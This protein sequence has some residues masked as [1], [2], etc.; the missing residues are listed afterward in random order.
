MLQTI[1]FAS[2]AA[3]MLSVFMVGCASSTTANT[4]H[5]AD[6]NLEVVHAAFER[7]RMGTGGPFE[8]L[9][10]ETTW[11]IVGSSPF[12]KTY[13]SKKHFMDEVIGPFNARLTRPLVPTVRRLYADGD[14]VVALFDGEALAKDGIVYRNTYAWFLQMNNGRIVNSTAFFDTRIFDEFWNRVPPTA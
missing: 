2:M 9:E 8:L 10:D 13:Q 3:I 5:G 12:S 7:W 1:R 6:S 14:T 4:T 11:T